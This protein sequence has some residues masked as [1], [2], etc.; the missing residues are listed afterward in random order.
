MHIRYTLLLINRV[1]SPSNFKITALVCLFLYNKSK[2]QSHQA[3]SQVSPTANPS[4]N[5]SCLH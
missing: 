3:N 5:I 4:Y 1:L 2:Q